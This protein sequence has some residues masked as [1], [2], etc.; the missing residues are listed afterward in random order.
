M[1]NYRYYLLS[2]IFILFSL[3]VFSN[4]KTLADSER[5]IKD[6]KYASAFELLH[7]ADT[8][9][10]NANIIVAKVNLLLDYYVKTDNFTSFALKDLHPNQSINDLREQ[11]LVIK[12]L[13]FRPDS[14]LKNAI[15][16]NPNNYKLHKVLGNFYYET[17]L[18]YH[19]EWIL[20]ETEL[21]NNI[22]EYNLLAYKNGEF[23]FWSLFELGYSYLM[24]DDEDEAL[25]YLS[26]SL[27]LNSN[28]AL[29]HYNLAYI[30][31]SKE[32]N[33]KALY[34]ASKA[35]SLQSVEE[36]KAEAANLLAMCYMDKK[37]LEK[38]LDY[39]R[40]SNEIQP[41][42]Y[43]TLLAILTLDLEVGDREYLHIAEQMIKL[44]PSNA[45]I[46][47][48]LLKAFSETERELDFIKF[49]ESVKPQHRAN[50]SA[51]ANIYLHQAIA[52]YEMEEW[53]SAK[54]NFEKSRSLFRNFYSS[55]H[56]VFRV[57][58]SYTKAI[59]KQI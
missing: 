36:Y 11:D 18:E 42:N 47:Q 59:K 19:D 41:N 20:S 28:Y 2:F 51:M 33:D 45:V 27:E 50:N 23:D 29:T 57:I 7:Q 21:I 58:D 56:S 31:H 13:E 10:H 35:F 22:K 40:K 48:D 6:R 53:V 12:M 30:Y 14:I 1:K 43:A 39:Y 46:Y 32:N 4:D 54:L 38:A 9:N 52:Q 16:E 3:S 55:D 44:S 26:K 25:K 5:L 8:Y 17:Y 24:T 49:M 37:D 34:H 15:K